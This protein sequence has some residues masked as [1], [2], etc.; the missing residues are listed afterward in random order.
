MSLFCRESS[1]G[2]SHFYEGFKGLASS[3]QP[4]PHFSALT[5]L[6]SP[7][8]YPTPQWLP[9]HSR[10]RWARSPF[11]A[12]TIV[13]IL[14]L[15]CSSLRLP[16]GS[17]PYWLGVFDQELPSGNALPNHPGDCSPV[18]LHPSTPNSLPSLFFSIALTTRRHLLYLILWSFSLHCNVCTKRAGIILLFS[19][20]FLKNPQHLEQSQHIMSFQ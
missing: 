5:S 11:S 20:C 2:P 1:S 17:L 12:F 3:P 9:S 16:P 6:H 4:V 13:F 15:E 10:T 14:F 7:V 8:S 18:H 19:H